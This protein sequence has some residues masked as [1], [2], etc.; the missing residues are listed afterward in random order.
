MRVSRTLVEVSGSLETGLLW[1]LWGGWVGRPIQPEAFCSFLGVS[2][3]ILLIGKNRFCS[4]KTICQPGP[5]TPFPLLFPFSRLTLISSPWC[6]AKDYVPC[7]ILLSSHLIGYWTAHYHIGNTVMGWPREEIIERWLKPGTLLWAS[8][9]WELEIIL[10]LISWWLKPSA[11]MDFLLFYFIFSH[12]L[13]I[14]I[15]SNVLAVC[16]WLC[17]IHVTYNVSLCMCL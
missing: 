5:L 1:G 17:M 13:C 2:H 4:R 8:Q 14:G 3:Q 7:R 9:E 16:P 15:Q 12:L 11:V 10:F 6:W